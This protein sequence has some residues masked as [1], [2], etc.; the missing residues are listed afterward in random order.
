MIGRAVDRYL[1]SVVAKVVVVVL[2][3]V[4]TLVHTLGIPGVQKMPPYRI[5][6]DVYRVGGQVFRDGGDLYGEL[7][8]L[9]EGQAL[10]IV[11]PEAKGHET[12]PP[13]R[14]T[15]ASLTKRL[16]DLGIGRPSTYA[17]II[18]TISDRG[19]VTKKGQALVPS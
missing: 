11:D 3:L 17:A 7:P 15:E 16:E 4:G 10:G 2:A 1:G 12:S 9:A 6:L 8:Q 13:P 14:Y 18:G 19:Y 5:D